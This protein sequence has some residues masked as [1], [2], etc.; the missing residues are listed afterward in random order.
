MFQYDFAKFVL[1]FSG[2]LWLKLIARIFWYCSTLLAFLCRD[3]I[4]FLCVSEALMFQ[5]SVSLVLFDWSVFQVFLALRR[6]FYLILLHVFVISSVLIWLFTYNF[7]PFLRLPTPFSGFVPPLT[8]LIKTRFFYSY[9]DAE[10]RQSSRIL[11]TL[12]P[13]P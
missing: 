4:S 7:H 9:L 12:N 11:Y 6:G 8:Q 5:F 1:L 3:P 13:K 2:F 10:S